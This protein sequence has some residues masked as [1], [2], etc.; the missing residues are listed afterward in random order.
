MLLALENAFVKRILE[1]T[2]V[3]CAIHYSIT[4]HGDMVLHVKCAIVVD[5]QKTASI[6]M[7]KDMGF[8]KAAQV[9]QLVISATNACQDLVEIPTVLV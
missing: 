6:V 9:T 2:I 1:V 5:W 8:V 3:N 4:N 7:Q